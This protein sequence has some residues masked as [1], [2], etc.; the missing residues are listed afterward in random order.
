[1][2]VRNIQNQTTTEMA[3]DLRR[4]YRNF[5]LGPSYSLFAILLMVQHFASESRPVEV[6][7]W[8]QSG[9]FLLPR[10]YPMYCC[11]TRYGTK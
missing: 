8:K 7:A 10:T 1:M 11:D 9:L 6:T 5:P 3:D 2:H 4:G